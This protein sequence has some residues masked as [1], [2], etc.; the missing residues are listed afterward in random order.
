[1]NTTTNTT[2]AADDA[3]NRLQESARRM[4]A[5]AAAAESIASAKVKLVLGRD[6][7]SVFFATL[8]LRLKYRADWNTPT[9][10]TNGKDLIYNPDFIAGLGQNALIGLLAHEVMH[11][12]LGHHTRRNER[13]PELWNVACDAAINPLLT[14][15]GF[16]LPADGI[17]PGSGP[18]AS[19]P[20]GLS[21]EQYYAILSE[22]PDPDGDQTAPSGSDAGA[23]SG[24]GTGS[25]DGQPDPHGTG[26]GPGPGGTGHDG[27][28]GANPFGEVQDAGAP[29]SAALK[30][31]AADWQVATAQAQQAARGRGELPG[32]LGRTIDAELNPAVDWRDLLREF[33]TRTARNDYDW[34][35]PN[36]RHIEAGIYLPSLRSDEVRPLIVAIDTSGSI[37]APTL[38]RFAAELQTVTEQQPVSLTILYHD[39]RIQHVQTWQPS[40]GEL[41]LEPAGGGGTDHRPIFAWLDSDDCPPDP[42]AVILFTDLETRFPTDPP[43][44][45]CLWLATDPDNDAPFGEV[46]RMPTARAIAKHRNL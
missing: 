16:S 36:R 7:K 8:A 27:T 15:A 10:A 32:E 14:E 28:P 12:A 30:E 19:A 1:M 24:T 18:L 29:D 23:E 43:A 42:A 45:P 5:E 39:S 38:A 26:S 17:Q 33:V 2:T 25:G 31:S 3:L 9:A 22:Q 35:R 13:D 46:V 34:N 37:D 20:A 21:A 44:V 41:I 40:D 11:L 6:A 4:T